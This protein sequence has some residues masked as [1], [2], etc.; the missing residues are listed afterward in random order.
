MPGAVESPVCGVHASAD[1]GVIM[2]EDAAYWSFVR[3]ESELGLW[4]GVRYG[5]IKLGK[6][7]GRGERGVPLQELR[8]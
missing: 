2:D 7:S 1:Y 6:T 8:A 4:F 3:G 5:D